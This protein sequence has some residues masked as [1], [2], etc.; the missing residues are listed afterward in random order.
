MELR[1][2][3]L[4]FLLT[5]SC[6]GQDKKSKADNLFFGY[7]Y[8]QAI[9]EYKKEMAKTQLDNQQYLNLADAY[10]KTGDYKNAA[11]TYTL[12]YKRDSTLSNHNFNKMLLSIARTDGMERVN[13]YLAT[14]KALLPAEW[15]ENANFNA[16]LLDSDGGDGLKYEIL[17]IRGNSAQ[18]DFSPTFYGEKLLFT[19]SRS[20]K[21]KDLYIPSGES[22]M[23]IFIGR[24]SQN[25]D[26]LNANAFNDMPPS[27]FHEATPFYSQE[28]ESIFYMLSNAEDGELSF[29][30]NGKNALAI[31]MVDQKGVFKYLLRDLGTSF[32]Y[33]FYD[34]PT[35]KLYFSANFGDSYGGTD[36]YYVYTNQGQIMSAPVNLG[37][38]I[39]TAGNEIAPFVFDNSLYFSSD[40]FYGLGGMDIY[41]SNL[42]PD[43]SFSIPVNLGREINST[44]DDFG[45]IIKD[46]STGGLMG[47]FASNREGG[48][49]KDDIYSFSVSEKPGLKTLVLSGT[50]A[51]PSGTAIDRAA[52]RVYDIQMELLKEVYTSENGQY[53][54]EIPWRDS[55]LVGAAKERFSS[56]TKALD[57]KSLQA[58]NN[59]RLNISLTQLED[60]IAE[61]EGQTVIKL[62]KF[63]FDRSKS[64]ITPEIAGELD[65]V[66]AA[67]KDFPKLQ[68]RIESHTDSRGGSSTNFKLSQQRADAIKK[69]LLDNGVSTSNILYTVGYGEDKILNNCTNGVYCLEMLHQQNDR[70]LIV[71]LNYDLLF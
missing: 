64:T 32:Y 63:L 62:N 61:K 4:F 8:K 65:K 66:V 50:V 31:G 54:L 41:R 44:Y 3:V 36:I 2:L 21:S 17:N 35:G 20:Q 43:D 68:L 6:F 15:I 57:G 12:V 28:L 33:P 52:V 55:I 19:S 42:M 26:I 29:D 38:R 13:A 39:N 59:G 34:A 14:K 69:Y 30:E 27:K 53:H 5:I 58:V 1:I 67:V 45:F 46:S 40:V 49:G 70:S 10:L 18:A 71:V 51:K 23:D 60:L 47:Y 37:P 9:A 22:F 25:G 24:V 56:F 16:E 11:T 48:K 7:A